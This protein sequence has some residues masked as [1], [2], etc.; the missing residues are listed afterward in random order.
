MLVLNFQ[1]TANATICN[2]RLVCSM[3]KSNNFC[4]ESPVL[5]NLSSENLVNLQ[6][7]NAAR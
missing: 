5:Q 4:E 7:E 6:S 1:I 2:V 3:L